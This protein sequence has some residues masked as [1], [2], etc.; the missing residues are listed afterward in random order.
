MPC[1]PSV[2][3]AEQWDRPHHVA[4][5]GPHHPSATMTFQESVGFVQTRDVSSLRIGC[6]FV[7]LF[8]GTSFDSLKDVD[9]IGV[10]TANR[11]DVS[12]GGGIDGG[13]YFRYESCYSAVTGAIML[14]LLAP[15]L[16]RSSSAYLGYAGLG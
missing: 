7:S 13:V 11:Y 10:L 14:R 2:F 6:E 4:P 15:W 1:K 5:A 12:V 8:E 16:R 3:D 9:V